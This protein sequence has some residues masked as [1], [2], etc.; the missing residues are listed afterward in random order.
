MSDQKH[1]FPLDYQ[2]VD[3]AISIHVRNLYATFGEAKVKESLSSLFGFE[4]REQ[5]LVCIDEPC[6]GLPKENVK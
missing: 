2:P 5:E 4:V 1:K 6:P 3:V